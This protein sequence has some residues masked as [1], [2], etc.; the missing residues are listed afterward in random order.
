MPAWRLRDFHDDDLD[1]ATQV[2]DQSRQADGTLPVFPVSE[3]MASA[4]AGQPAVVAVVADEVVGLAVAQV[5]GERAW[6]LLVALAARWNAGSARTASDGSARCC[7][8][9]P[10][11]RWRC[12]TVATR[13]GR[14]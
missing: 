12:T 9:T 3:V 14:D 8:R 1:Q 13:P 4:R 2:W 10:P 6:V 11:A 5:E 7:P